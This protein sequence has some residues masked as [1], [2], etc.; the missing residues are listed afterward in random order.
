[1]L[2]RVWRKGTLL[3]CRWEC[4]L[5]QPLWRTVWRLFKKKKTIIELPNDPTIP[6][7]GKYPE[8]ATIRK[9]TCTPVF[10]A[11]PFIIAKTWKLHKCQSTSEWIKEMWYLYT[12]E[13]YFA[14]KKN[15]IMPFAAMWM[16]LEMII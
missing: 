6:L 7:L 9:D 3:Y 15:E 16:D 12:M 1:M 14:I 8:K 5:V 11:A 10:I 2:E 13:Y 4:K